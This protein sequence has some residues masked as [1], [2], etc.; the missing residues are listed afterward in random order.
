MK[1]KSLNQ[2]DFFADK[3]NFFIANN[4]MPPMTIIKIESDVKTKTN[5]VL[6]NVE[7]YHFINLITTG[8]KVD[9]SN[10]SI[11]D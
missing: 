5:S 11:E 4:A 6:A 9:Y 8:I 2:N 3:T 1:F 10:I 7:K